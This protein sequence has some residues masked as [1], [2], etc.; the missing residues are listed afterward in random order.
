MIYK[1]IAT[2]KGLYLF[3]AA[4]C[5]S[6]TLQSRT[7]NMNGRVQVH[8]QQNKDAME[9]NVIDTGTRKQR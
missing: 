9:R 1:L 2:G 6:R 4:V 7:V 3:V 5:M 8:P